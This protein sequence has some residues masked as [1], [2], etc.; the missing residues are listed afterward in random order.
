MINRTY[1]LKSQKHSL[2][3]VEYKKGEST[4]FESI[5]F[6]SLWVYIDWLII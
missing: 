2:Y 6:S 5:L 3:R 1:Y 4:L